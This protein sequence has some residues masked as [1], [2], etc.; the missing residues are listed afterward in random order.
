MNTTWFGVSGTGPDNVWMVGQGGAVAQWNGTQW[1]VRL[2]QATF[3]P[4]SIFVRSSTELWIAGTDELGYRSTLVKWN[5]ATFDPVNTA[6]STELFAIHGVA[7][8]LW[9]VGLHGAI[10][11]HR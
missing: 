4:S 11:R 2:S 8:E 7:N 5:G 10:L 1:N 3:D 6:A 9:A